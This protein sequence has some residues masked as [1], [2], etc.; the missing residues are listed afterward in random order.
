MLAKPGTVDFLSL[1]ET[2]NSRAADGVVAE[3][4]IKI[5]RA[6]RPQVMFVHFPGVDVIGH[7][8][9][10]GS[11]EQISAAEQID[12]MIGRIFS[13]VDELDLRGSS[14]IIVTA[15]HGGAGITHG[16][17]DPRSRHIP[18]II[19]GPGIR[20]NYDLTLLESL[21]IN[22]EDTFAT[23]CG[24]LGIPLKQKIDGKPIMEILESRELIQGL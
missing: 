10:W 22:T 23:A 16:P 7:V 6:H 1:P 4:S 19:S 24:L 18:W 12:G 8:K 13:A 21:T 11:H 15:D 17:D 14:A 3:E 2:A 5:L 9:G 20:R